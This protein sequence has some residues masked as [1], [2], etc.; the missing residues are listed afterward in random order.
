MRG[1]SH[2][3]ACQLCLDFRGAERKSLLERMKR[4]WKPMPSK[5]DMWKRA[6]TKACTACLMVFAVFLE[7]SQQADQKER[8]S[9][10]RRAAFILVCVPR[11]L[12]TASEFP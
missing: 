4:F 11:L 9:E 12:Q 5:P 1:R 6:D 2:F 10:E 8:G 7:G 3:R